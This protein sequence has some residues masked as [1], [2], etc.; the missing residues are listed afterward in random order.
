MMIKN[1]LSNSRAAKYY[2]NQLHEMALAANSLEPEWEHA[3]IVQELLN[4]TRASIVEIIQLEGIQLTKSVGPL[5]E[6]KTEK[7]T[8]WLEVLRLVKYQYARYSLDYL[9][10]SEGLYSTLVALATTYCSVE[11]PMRIG[12]L[13]CGPGRS[14]LD[15]AK[16]FKNSIVLGLDYSILS[17]Q[18][19]Q[20]ILCSSEDFL[21]PI[22]S[23]S[24]DYITTLYTI[25]SQVCNNVQFGVFDIMEPAN[26]QFDLIVCSNTVNLLPNHNHAIRNLSQILLPGGII[27]FADLVGWRIDRQK[28]NQ[29][30]SSMNNIVSAFEKNNIKTL[31]YFKGGPYIEDDSTENKKLYIEYFYVGEKRGLG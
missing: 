13:G 22:R 18:I 11:K 2:S 30:L 15:F 12:V 3:Y 14:V 1:Y 20:N 5:Y 28:D 9:S 31:D 10:Y 16:V 4:E 27:V 19:A 6:R 8:T 7:Y 17:L 24:D 25:K 21:F 26:I 29:S 23:V